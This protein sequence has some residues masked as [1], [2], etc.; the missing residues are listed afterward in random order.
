MVTDGGHISRQCSTKYSADHAFC[1]S[2]RHACMWCSLMLD[3]IPRHALFDVLFGAHG[4]RIHRFVV[5]KV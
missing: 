2:H 3:D 1:R 5:P 4:L